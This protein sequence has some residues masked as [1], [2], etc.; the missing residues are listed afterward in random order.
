M[1]GNVGLDGLSKRERDVRTMLRIAQQHFVV[2]IA[3]IAGFEKHRR[4]VRPPENVE[5]GETVWFR[6]KLESARRTLDQ[7]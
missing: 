4:R 3:E 2:G 1:R 5:C 6:T 7:P